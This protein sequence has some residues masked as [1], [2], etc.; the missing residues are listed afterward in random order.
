MSKL[1]A[2][3]ALVSLSIVLPVLWT[4]PPPRAAEPSVPPPHCAF[5][6]FTTLGHGDDFRDMASP[7][8]HFGLSSPC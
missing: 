8:H 5:A 4:A 2:C 6:G 3:M 1:A 7:V